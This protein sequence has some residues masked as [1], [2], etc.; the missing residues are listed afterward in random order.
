[1]S[2]ASTIL[3]IK[4]QE[5]IVFKGLTNIEDIVKELQIT[6]YSE[7]IVKKAI[8][9]VHNNKANGAVW[10]YIDDDGIVYFW[11]EGHYLA[12]INEN[13]KVMNDVFHTDRDYKKVV[14]NVC[15]ALAAGW[16]IR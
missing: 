5:V 10:S 12:A 14:E 16:Q 13:A 3:K 15:S 6:K 9:I 4:T 2:P 8:K 11:N 1:M 7:E